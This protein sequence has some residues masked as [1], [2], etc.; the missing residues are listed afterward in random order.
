MREARWTKSECTTATTSRRSSVNASQRQARVLRY[1][2]R[3]S[4][5]TQRQQSNRQPSVGE[6]DEHNHDH[7][8]T[9][10]GQWWL[11]ESE[12]GKRT[13]DWTL[14]AG[15]ARAHGLRELGRSTQ[16]SRARSEL[17]M[18]A[19]LWPSRTRSMQQGTMSRLAELKEAQTRGSATAL[20][21]SAMGS[22]GRAPCECREQRARG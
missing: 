9:R 17:R 1:N 8:L 12:L 22:Q 14:T 16:W 4:A 10:I 20:G 13:H 19:R 11:A 3:H 2:R 6:F 18:T 5:S 21:V 15:S 7:M